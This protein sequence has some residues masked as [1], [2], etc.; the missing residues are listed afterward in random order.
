MTG[1]EEPESIRD[2]SWIHLYALL[3]SGK[4]KKMAYKI[5]LVEDDRQIREIIEDYF[6][7][8]NRKEEFKV[9]TSADGIS[10]MDLLDENEYDLILLDVMLPGLD[11]FTI[12]KRIRKQ[13]D[14]PVI[15]LTARTLEEDILLGFETGCD[16]YVTKP[17]SLATLYAKSIALLHRSRGCI[18]GGDVTVG[19]ITINE[20]TMKVTVSG[21]EVRL[22]PKEF[23]LL[24]FFCRHKNIVLSR[25]TLLNGVW[26][27][28]FEGGDRVVDNHVKKLRKALGPSRNQIK[29]V[30]SKGYR[31]TE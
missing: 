14:V 16:D 23:D 21:E 25:E 7:D 5:L 22:K 17:F 2:I 28:D 10:A 27:M 18:I 12:C 30:I 29:T 3:Y 19:N 20:N 1:S 4:E 9:V 15:F 26:G 6:T 24:L 13:S 11:G 8:E 31:F